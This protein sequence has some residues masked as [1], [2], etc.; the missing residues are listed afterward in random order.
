MA[1]AFGGVRGSTEGATSCSLLGRS[2]SVVLD[3]HQLNTLQQQLRLQREELGLGE[4]TISPILPH[5]VAVYG[6]ARLPNHSI[7]A[8]TIYMRE[9]K[10]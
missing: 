1:A 9:S 3:E 2:K 10:S 7:V 5:Q 6:Q 8:S 4:Y